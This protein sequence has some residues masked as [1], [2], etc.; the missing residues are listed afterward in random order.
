MKFNGI[1]LFPR[2]SFFFFLILAGLSFKALCSGTDEY[3]GRDMNVGRV[4]M[5]LIGSEIVDREP[6]Q[7]LLRDIT[8]RCEGEDVYC[9]ESQA[10]YKLEGR[11]I[12]YDWSAKIEFNQRY[13]DFGEVPIPESWIRAKVGVDP[14]TGGHIFYRQSRTDSTTRGRVVI[15]KLENGVILTLTETRPV[16]EPKQ[17]LVD[18]AMERWRVFDAAAK[19]FA[20]FDADPL[21][22]ISL[23]GDMENESVQ[24]GDVIYLVAHPD[25]PVILP[26]EIKAKPQGVQPGK[27]YKFVLSHFSGSDSL[28][29]V[30]GGRGVNSFIEDYDSDTYANTYEITSTSDSVIMNI[31]MSLE[32]LEIHSS[33]GARESIISAFRVENEEGR[34]D[35]F[36]QVSPWEMVIT[37]FEIR[38][39]GA[40][41]SVKRKPP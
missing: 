25:H 28:F 15:K 12:L 17:R 11:D 22:V 24:D 26:L 40:E 39:E 2:I 32:S 20:L 33:L 3:T 41:S 19:K 35:F 34:I 7:A 16:L 1:P 18:R 30:T 9:F 37:R 14:G 5:A 29:E 10:S 13:A 31:E 23:G 36:V 8:T 6:G 27:N 4:V 21:E 38:Q